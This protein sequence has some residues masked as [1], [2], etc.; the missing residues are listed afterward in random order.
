MKNKKCNILTQSQATGSRA[1]LED[2]HSQR[3]LEVRTPGPRKFTSSGS[4]EHL[5]IWDILTDALKK[6][7]AL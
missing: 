2:V 5:Y 7:Q 1:K 6:F 3:I 4:R